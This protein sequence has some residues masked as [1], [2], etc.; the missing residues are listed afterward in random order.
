MSPVLYAI[1]GASFVVPMFI[2]A[3]PLNFVRH[4]IECLQFNIKYKILGLMADEEIPEVNT[5]IRI[6]ANI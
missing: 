1:L 4:L 2:S 6:R 5:K 3:L